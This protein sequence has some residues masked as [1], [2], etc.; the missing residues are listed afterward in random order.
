MLIALKFA[1]FSSELLLKEQMIIPVKK[2][3]NN[4]GHID[5]KLIDFSEICQKNPA[6]S[7]VFYWLFLGEVSPR[8]FPWNRPIFLPM[9]ILQNLTFSAKTREIGR[10]VCEFWL[11]PA[12]IPRNRPIFPRILTFFPRKSREIGQFSREFAP[13]NPAKFFVFFR[14]ISEALSRIKLPLKNGSWSTKMESATYFVPSLLVF[15][16]AKWTEH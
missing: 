11:S 3:L 7:A 6:K 1:H 5:A 10:F 4:A 9:K 12:N 15:D 2:T 13:E 14:E 16:S 8:N